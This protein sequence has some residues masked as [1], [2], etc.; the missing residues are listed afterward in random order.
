MRAEGGCHL[1][2]KEHQG[3]A[4]AALQVG[5]LI[6]TQRSFDEGAGKLCTLNAS[7]VL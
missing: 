6:R 4:A 1:R 2:L 7:I 3:P 5:E